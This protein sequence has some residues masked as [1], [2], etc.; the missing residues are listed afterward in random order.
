[1][2]QFASNFMMQL[3]V[4]DIDQWWKHIHAANLAEAFLVSPPKPPQKQPWGLVVAYFSDPSCVLW[5]V[6]PASGE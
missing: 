2:E 4:P 5:H 6:T 1:V 3:V